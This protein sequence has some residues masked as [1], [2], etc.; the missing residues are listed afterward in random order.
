MA[1]LVPVTT[2]G[3]AHCESADYQ[4]P[5]LVYIDSRETEQGDLIAPEVEGPLVCAMAE[6][7]ELGVPM[8]W[9]NRCFGFSVEGEF[10]ERVTI[11]R[12]SAEMVVG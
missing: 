9:V 2:A 11:A 8:S 7:V 6:A 4:M 1:L 12:R 10:E 3:S 5:V